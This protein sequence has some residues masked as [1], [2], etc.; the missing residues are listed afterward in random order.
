MK[1]T[2]K[3]SKTMTTILFGIA[4]ILILLLFSYFLKQ[5][6]NEVPAS[7]KLLTNAT[8]VV[9]ETNQIMV[10]FSSEVGTI[11]KYTDGDVGFEEHGIV[12]LLTN[13][14]EPIVNEEYVA[15]FTVERG[16]SGT[17][18]YLTLFIPGENSYQAQNSVFLGDRIIIDSLDADKD[19]NISVSYREHGEDQAMAEKPTTIVK[20]TFTYQELI[21]N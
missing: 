20:K 13:Y 21:N 2:L 18:T 9:P 4:L 7:Q 12:T 6:K 11:A 19:N 5:Q 10:N 3:T 1:K 17:E 16:G 14:I 8:L 15:F